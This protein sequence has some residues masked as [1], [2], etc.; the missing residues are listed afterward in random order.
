MVGHISTYND[1]SVNIQKSI[2]YYKRWYVYINS[3][4]VLIRVVYYVEVS[5][6]DGKKVIW[7]VLDDHVF[8]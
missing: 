1:E 3:K 7:E 4:K 8:K 5:G 6:S 2:I